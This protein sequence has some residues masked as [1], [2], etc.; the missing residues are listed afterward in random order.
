MAALAKKPHF[1]GME[2]EARGRRVGGDRTNDLTGVLGT[3]T[4]GRS[5]VR[6]L[7]MAGRHTERAAVW[8]CA[9]GPADQEGSPR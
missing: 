2:T 3:R 7:G 4:D 9:R 5:V 1:A 6:L 8:P